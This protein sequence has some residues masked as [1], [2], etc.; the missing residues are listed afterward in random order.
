[1]TSRR[2]RATRGLLALAASAAAFVGAA[3]L[4]AASVAADAPATC[5]AAVTYDPSILSFDQYWAA[6]KGGTLPADL[7]PSVPGQASPS[8]LAPLAVTPLGA[9]GTGAGGGATP[10]GVGSDPANPTGRN[11]SDVLLS[12]ADYLVKATA[13]N[14]RVRVVPKE[15]GTSSLGKRIAFYAVGTPV[16]IANLDDGRDDAAFW[17]G[18]RAGDIP[19]DQGL[20]AA[21]ERPAFG[22]I[23]ATPHGGESAAGES[24]TRQLYELAARTDCANVKRVATL[25]LFLQLVRNP[26]GRDAVTRYTAY[27]FDPNRDF[28][29]RNYVENSAFIPKMNDYPGLFFIDAHQQGG[30]AYF[31]PPNEDPVHHEISSFSLDTIQNKIGPSLQRAF[32]D[33]STLYNN[34]SQYDLFTP[35]YGDTVP[36]LIMGA[37]GMTYEKGNAEVYPKQVYDHFLAIDTTINTIANDK[38]ATT[39]AWVEQWQDA[40]QQGADCVLQPNKLVSPLHDE[41]NP[42]PA[43]KRVCG[44]F[45]RPGEHT[46]DVAKLLTEMQQVG[47]KVFRLNADTTLKGVQEY[48]KTAGTQTLPAGTLY[49]PMAQGMKHWIQAVMGE[50]PFIPYPFYYDVVTWS[51][52]LQRGLAGDGYLTDATSVPTDLTQIGTPDLGGAPSGRSKVFAFNTDS[53]KS[54]LLAADLLDKGVDVSRGTTAFE[55][56]GTRYLTG[57]ALVDGDALAAKGVDLN[58]LAKARQTPVQAL[59]RYPVARKRMTAPKIG[60]YTGSATV[61]PNPLYRGTSGNLTADGYC[62]ASSA[63]N[64]CEALFVLRVKE[65]LSGSVVRPIT[66]AQI[67]AGELTSGGYTAIINPNYALSTTSRTAVQAFVSGGGRYVGSGANGTSSATNAGLSSITTNPVP[68]TMRTPGSTYDATFDTSDPVAW[69]FDR[70]GWIY[71]QSGDPMYDPASVTGATAAVVRYASDLNSDAS[72]K[73]QKYGL[74]VNATG[75]GLLDGRPAVAGTALGAG[76]STVFGWNVFFRAWKDQDERLLLNA[77]MFPTTPTLPADAA[78]AK[79]T[80]ETIADAPKALTAKTTVEAEPALPKAERPKVRKA[81]TKR[82][83]DTT[84]DFQLVVARKHLAGLKRAVKAAK[85][86]KALRGKVAYKAS[87]AK[88]RVVTLTIR[89]ARASDDF[90][91]RHD[92]VDRLMK[93]VRKQGVKVRMGQL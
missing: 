40:V 57:A 1:M 49:I 47:V 32:N 19:E 70:G 28:G 55:A 29:T 48:G 53:A 72:L 78:P 68:S 37:A 83:H 11:Q 73:G 43:D 51:Y 9:G 15:I 50:N 58:A 3:A 8:E 85:L 54:L 77:A 18:V 67:D 82:Q 59:D 45:F 20:D 2:T 34:Y 6:V 7:T 79:V 92:W 62:G 60:L 35:E 56:G 93:Q 12:Y 52:G 5:P 46:G 27:G 69:G 66:S 90:H 75:P 13:S 91:D 86:P 74:S 80:P 22:W 25:D 44:Y 42:I 33:T 36:S 61:P 87:G 10:G 76:R 17:R 4:P 26:D 39:R 23:T 65:G 81:T 31:F 84:K 41:V 71:R 38:V 88:V 64:F 21:A 24:I 14:P 16:N 89:D 63:A 30:A